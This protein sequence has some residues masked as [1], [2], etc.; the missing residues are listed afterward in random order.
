[1]RMA[2]TNSRRVHVVAV[3]LLDLVALF[4]IPEFR[5]IVVRHPQQFRV[6]F[7]SSPARLYI[8][9]SV[10]PAIAQTRSSMAVLARLRGSLAHPGVDKL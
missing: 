6:D 1:M 3:P 7:L 5:R 10:V 9:A 2:S 8:S 4:L